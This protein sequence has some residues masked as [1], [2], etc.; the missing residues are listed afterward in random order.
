MLE[1]YSLTS[2][3]PKEELYGLTSQIR[4]AA[5][6]VSSNIAEGFVRLGDLDKRRFYYTAL[7]SLTELQNQ[8]LIAKDLGYLS[9]EGFKRIAEETVRLAKMLNRLIKIISTKDNC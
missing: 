6:S 1:V 2:D 9:S 5:V 4:R 7:G 3:F 8:L